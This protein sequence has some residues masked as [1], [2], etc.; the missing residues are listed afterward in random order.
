MIY[1]KP[2]YQLNSLLLSPKSMFH[3]QQPIEWSCCDHHQRNKFCIQD[4]DSNKVLPMAQCMRYLLHDL[5]IN[6]TNKIYELGALIIIERILDCFQV[7][8]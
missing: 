8:S 3:G 6:K 2:D 7:K 4:L 5:K 1:A